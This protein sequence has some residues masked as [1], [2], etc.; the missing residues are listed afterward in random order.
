MDRICADKYIPTITD[1]IRTRTK[2]I[3]ITDMR[4]DVGDGKQLRL[5]DVG[6]QRNE[7]RKWIHF[8]NTVDAVVFLTALSEFDLNLYEDNGYWR[9][10][11]SLR[12]FNEVVNNALFFKVPFVLVFNKRDLFEEKIANKSFS[13]YFSGFNGDEKSPVDTIDFMTK[14]FLNEITEHPLETV[15]VKTLSAIDHDNTKQVFEEVK[16]FV[17]AQQKE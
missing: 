16:Q 4:F 9:V 12:V 15:S 8:F 1:V 5:V 2:T 10:K 17:L 13:K 11:E 14:L 3:G 6:G 7:R